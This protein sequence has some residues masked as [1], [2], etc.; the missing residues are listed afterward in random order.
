MSLALSAPHLAGRRYGV[1][2][3]A[4]SGLATLEFLARSG[5]AAL[6]WDDRPD[7]RAA[8]RGLPRVDLVDLMT[9][10][11]RGLAGLVVSPGVPLD[12]HPLVARARAEGVPILGDVQLFAEARPYLP[13][14]RVVG[15]TGTNGK[16]TVTA[17][18]HHLL[19]TAGRPARACGNIGRPIL[20][21]EPLP[22][23]GVWV[24]E[25]SSFQI[26]LLH[27]LACDIAILTNVTPDHLDRYA[28]FADYAAA[29]ARLF[30]L[31]GPGGVAIV[32]TDTPAA[33][34]I[35]RALPPT[36]SVV[37]VRAA[38]VAPEDQ[39]RWPALKGPHNAQNAACAIAAARALGL[40]DL[41]IAQGLTTYQ[42]LPHRME[43]VATLGGVLFVNDSK[44]TNPDSA[45]PALAAFPAIHWIAGGQAKTADLAPCLP[46]LGHVRHAWLIGEAA[47]LFHDLL[48]PHVPVTVA[49]T[50]DSAV[51]GAARAARPGETVLLSPACASF[52][53]FRDFEHRGDA[54]RAAV[55]ALAEAA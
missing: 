10:E 28:G 41:G 26:D 5:A 7:A 21:E 38:D 54:F 55:R 43:R 52:D 15:V 39:A 51:R 22:H 27:T 33:A 17:L 24:L 50:L 29:K 19:T 4:R 9:A 11:L 16:S 2:G 35:A 44:A 49:G 31:Q 32:A 12:R 46:H 25:L 48:S 14:H 42:G 37:A 3:L 1:L 20:A 40:D 8:A 18:L 6:A 34:A 45:A 47:P 30:A 23:G 13:P 36:L 53:Q